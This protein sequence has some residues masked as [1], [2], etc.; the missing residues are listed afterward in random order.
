[1]PTNYELDY[2][3]RLE[4]ESRHKGLYDWSIREF[5]DEKQVGPD[6]I[7]FGWGVNFYATDLRLSDS[8]AI[9]VKGNLSDEADKAVFARRRFIRAELKTG[10]PQQK[11]WSAPS[12]SYFGRRDEV[13]HITLFI[14][15]TEEGQVEACHLAGGLPFAGS[16]GERHGDLLE[17]QFVVNLATFEDLVGRVRER[18]VDI[19]NLRLSRVAGLYSEWSPDIDVRHLKLLTEPSNHRL[20]LSSARSITPKSM[21]V[22]K[23][24]VLTLHS[25]QSF[26]TGD[27]SEEDEPASNAGV[28]IVAATQALPKIETKEIA[29]RLKQIGWMLTGIFLVLIFILVRMKG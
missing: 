20:D 24:A 23:E 4:P 27:K 26:H 2:S 3:V 18:S 22:V 19:A 21:G 17:V 7:P 9:E 16:Y 13:G 5:E 15:P 14:R 10:F 29:E 25:I 8:V 12:L 11:A 28:A 1:M 6:Y